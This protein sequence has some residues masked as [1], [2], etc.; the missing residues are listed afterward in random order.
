MPTK[1]RTS[2]DREAERIARSL[3]AY[4]AT[5]GWL[6]RVVREEEDYRAEYGAVGPLDYVSVGVSP[7]GS[8]H[9]GVFVFTRFRDVAVAAELPINKAYGNPTLNDYSGKWNFAFCNHTE[10]DVLNTIKD[11]FDKAGLP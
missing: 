8:R 2:Q 7:R 3:V 6:P 11:Q 5:R 10:T 4:L 1:R 9:V